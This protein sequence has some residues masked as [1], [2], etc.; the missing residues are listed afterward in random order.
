[1]HFRCK[2]G[3]HKYVIVE[4]TFYD[5]G[6]MHDRGAYDYVCIYC[7]KLNLKAQKLKAKVKQESN[8]KQRAKE[9]YMENAPKDVKK[10]YF[11]KH[12]NK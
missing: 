6:D 1:M 3:L 4:G 11:A 10:E 9:I 12:L 7:S 5:G 8:N 2:I